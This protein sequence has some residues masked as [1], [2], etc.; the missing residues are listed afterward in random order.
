MSGSLNRVFL[1]GNVG[2]DPNI[3]ELTKALLAEFS[4]ATSESYKDK[5][6]TQWQK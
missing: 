4:L 5:D 3:K 2:G 6:K 1:I